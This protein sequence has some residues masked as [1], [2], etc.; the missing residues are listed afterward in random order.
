MM[1]VFNAR[2]YSP[3][4]PINIRTIENKKKK[5]TTKGAIP[6]EKLFQ[7]VNFLIKI[8]SS[9][10]NIYQSYNTSAYCR[11]PH[12]NFC[13]TINPNYGLERSGRRTEIEGLVDF[14]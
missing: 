9:Y 4:S 14:N 7:S 6:I 10:Y 11:N 12:G 1:R 2:T 13:I 3:M 5:P 8:I